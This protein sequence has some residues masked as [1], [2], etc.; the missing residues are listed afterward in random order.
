MRDVLAEIDRDIVYGIGEY[1]WVDAWAWGESAGGHLWRTT[2]DLEESLDQPGERRFRQVGREAYAGPGHWNDTDMLIVGTLSWGRGEPVP[3]NLTKNE[4]I[5][6][7]DEVLAVTMDT[8]GVAG[9][10]V[11]Q[12]GRLEVWARPSGTQ[13][14]RDLWTRSDLGTFADAYTVEVP[15]H[16]AVMVKVGR[17]GG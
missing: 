8:L 5:L 3:T 4:Q 11:W 1:G 14:V 7:N 10:R 2:S 6:Q 12:G 13:P 16:G 9:G 17:P 15:R